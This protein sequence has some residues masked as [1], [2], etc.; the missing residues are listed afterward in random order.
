MKGNWS[1]DEAKNADIGLSTKKTTK[2]QKTCAKTKKLKGN[3]R[4][5][6]LR[7]YMISILMS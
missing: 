5:Q 4:N 7:Q 6:R 3:A 2:K 1:G